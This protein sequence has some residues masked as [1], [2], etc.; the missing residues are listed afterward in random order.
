MLFLEP[1]MEYRSPLLYA[2][3]ADV[4]VNIYQARQFESV[5]LFLL[6]CDR[7]ARKLTNKALLEF[8][9]QKRLIHHA[10]KARLHGDYLVQ[11]PLRR[12]FINTTGVGK[13]K[14]VLPAEPNIILTAP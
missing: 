1:S 13:R 6:T 5:G 10:C 9:R 7:S 4:G 14:K 8:L 2:A 3:V 11:H 12:R